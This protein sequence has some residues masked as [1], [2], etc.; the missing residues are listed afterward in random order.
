M[1]TKFTLHLQHNQAIF[2]L[3]RNVSTVLEA[4][5][6]FSLVTARPL[7]Q[8]CGTQY[9]LILRWDSQHS[10][11]QSAFFQNEGLVLTTRIDRSWISNNVHFN[12]IYE[13]KLNPKI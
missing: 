7:Q 4:T 6:S 5:A 13:R 10:K 3:G 2:Y 11:G 1:S 12:D 9:S 8:A